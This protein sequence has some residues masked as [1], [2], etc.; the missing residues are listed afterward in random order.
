MAYMAYMAYM[1]I[2]PH[3]CELCKPHMYHIYIYDIFFPFAEALQMRFG[4][5]ESSAKRPHKKRLT[6]LAHTDTHQHC[7]AY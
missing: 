5:A 3:M 2:W 1:G 7:G 6:R 4:A